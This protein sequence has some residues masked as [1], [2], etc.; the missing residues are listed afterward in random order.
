MAAKK[1]KHDDDNINEPQVVENDVDDEDKTPAEREVTTTAPM[2][3]TVEIAGEEI[4]L[5]DRYRKDKAP[6]AMMMIGHESYAAKYLP[7]LLET[8]IG[9]DQTMM[10]LFEKGASIEEMGNI[11]Q[12]WAEGRGLKN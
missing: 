12:A 3:F 8:L 4:E 1:T 10:V 6:G 9:E 7:G 5:E 2:T 11:T